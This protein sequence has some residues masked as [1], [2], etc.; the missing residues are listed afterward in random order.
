[1]TQQPA[2][3]GDASAA[4]PDL[5]CP[6]C[7]KP[8][9]L[10]VCEGIVR[11]DNKVSL[12]ILQHPQE[13]DRELGTARLAALH[14]KDALLKIGLSWWIYAHLARGYRRLEDPRSATV[15]LILVPGAVAAAMATIEA[16]LI[17]VRRPIMSS[18]RMRPSRAAC[19]QYSP[20]PGRR[21]GG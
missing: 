17:R 15:F 13:Q 6:H 19:G 5:E 9:A 4:D 11:I 20:K 16:R 1:M 12:I 10:C 14:C 18:S 3:A 7:R 8:P 2:A 21:T